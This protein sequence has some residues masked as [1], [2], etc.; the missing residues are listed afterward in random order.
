MDTLQRYFTQSH[1]A[2]VQ[3]IIDEKNRRGIEQAIAL[4]NLF[5]LAMVLGTLVLGFMAVPK[6]CTDQT[7][8]GKNTRLGMYVL[9][10]MTGGQIGWLYILLWLAK[11]NVCN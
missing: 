6:I 10:L 1:F 3:D 2:S 5:I 9:L 4:S 11:V 8:R 7:E